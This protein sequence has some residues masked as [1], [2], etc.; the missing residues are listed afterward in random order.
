MNRLSRRQ[1]AGH[2]DSQ[3][4]GVDMIADNEGAPVCQSSAFGWYDFNSANS[5]HFFWDTRL[6]ARFSGGFTAQAFQGN[7][8]SWIY[9]S[10][11]LFRQQTA[12]STG[13]GL[14]AVLSGGE[15]GVRIFG[16]TVRARVEDPGFVGTISGL[17]AQQGGVIHMH[18]GIVNVD[19]SEA[20][21]AAIFAIFTFLGNSFVHTPGTAFVLNG[22]P[23]ATVYRILNFGK[24]VQSPFLWPAST[25]APTTDGT[26]TGNPIISQDGSDLFVK[27]NE[28]PGQDES[29]LFVYDSSCTTNRWRSVTTGSCL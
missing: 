4:Q 18:G 2:G 16:S 8:E 23:G 19:T 9:A 29:H 27:T 12:V 17:K 13:S 5:L 14:S 6:E 26:A 10:D 28:G 24:G 25:H 3:W 20:T 11:I 21:A 22:A 7:G 1:R 15:K